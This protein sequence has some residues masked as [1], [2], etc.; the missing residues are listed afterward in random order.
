MRACWP[1]RE[2]SPPPQGRTAAPRAMPPPRRPGR[3]CRTRLR[4]VFS[5]GARAGC[6]ARTCLIAAVLAGCTRTPATRLLARAGE[7]L[8]GGAGAPLTIASVDDN[9]ALGWLAPGEG[10]VAQVQVVRSSDGG[11]TFSAPMPLPLPRVGARPNSPAASQAAL[12]PVAP[13]VRASTAPLLF[14]S[15]SEAMVAIWS[16]RDPAGH[17]LL[18]SRES[19]PDSRVFTVP[20]ILG[21]VA[22]AHTSGSGAIPIAT[23]PRGALQRPGHAGE[24]PISTWFDGAGAW[25]ELANFASRG[26]PHG[27]AAYAS[28]DGVILLVHRASPSAPPVVTAGPAEGMPHRSPFAD[29]GV[30]TQAPFVGECSG[31][32]VVGTSAAAPAGIALYRSPNA[33]QSW[34]R[35][36]VATPPGL[37]AARFA[38]AG[39][40]IAVAWAEPHGDDAAIV[41]ALSGDGGTRFGPPRI[42]APASAGLRRSAPWIATAGERVLVAWL[43]RS[44]GAE[45]LRARL[46]SDGGK[47][48]ADFGLEEPSPGTR[49]AA[50]TLWAAPSGVGIAWLRAAIAPPGAPMHVSAT[51]RTTF[52]D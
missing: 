6:G 47:T 25:R 18:A 36:A 50:P 9:I 35:S 30:Q 46:S 44:A 51:L 1:R 14:L 21:R 20:E 34:S 10:S 3:E 2:P 8:L 22:G 23:A 19:A 13:G 48:F 49:D 41:L 17:V 29:A 42:L 39:A 15:R 4:E 52:A 27:N 32:L 12:E 11:R 33:G 24:M 7:V 16:A 40:R 38:L 45:I 37:P 43:E 26:F 5:R 28:A 31:H